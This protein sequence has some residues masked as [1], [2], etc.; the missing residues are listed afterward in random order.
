MNSLEQLLGFLTALKS[1]NIH[2][3]IDCVRDAIMVVIPTPSRYYEVEF[4]ADGR[5]ESQAFGPSSPV[6]AVTLDEITSAVVG[7]VA[8]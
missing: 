7:D 1:A 2:H 3:S 8:G 6:V 5:I 4:F